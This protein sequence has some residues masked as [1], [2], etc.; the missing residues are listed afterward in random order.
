MNKFGATPS[1][2]DNI[3]FAS[4]REAAR[5]VQLKLLVRGKA[6]S[7]LKTH[8]RY[9]LV[10]NGELVGH[11]TPDFGYIENGKEV[12]EDIKGVRT[13]DYILRSKVFR[14]C[15]PQIALREVA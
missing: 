2:V 4:K 9:S 7:G 14:A 10:V 11:Y 13:T 5:Y 1:V 12:V 8:P 3:R 15:H 6:I